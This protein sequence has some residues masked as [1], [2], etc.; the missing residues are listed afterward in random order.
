LII[1]LGGG[2]H[3]S[4]KT[5]SELLSKNAMTTTVITPVKPKA[6]STKKP[7]TPNN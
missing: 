5:N 1:V 3:N 4:H 6:M 7:V 2:N